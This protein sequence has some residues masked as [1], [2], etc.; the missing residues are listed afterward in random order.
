MSQRTII[1]VNHD[2]ARL[3]NDDSFC[4]LWNRAIASGSPESWEP[5]RVY[6]I[7]RITQCHHSE[8]RKVV[9]GIGGPAEREYL[10]G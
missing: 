8:D 7:T 10:F 6:G 5:L 2:A 3:P 4:E 1:E 9:V